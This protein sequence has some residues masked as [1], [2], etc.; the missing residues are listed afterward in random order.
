MLPR[1][2]CFG[3]GSKFETLP[4]SPSAVI[5]HRIATLAHI[6]LEGFTVRTAYT[7]SQIVLLG[8]VLFFTSYFYVVTRQR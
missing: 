2:F 5:E 8:A 6:L 7:Y 3:G 1:I 4:T